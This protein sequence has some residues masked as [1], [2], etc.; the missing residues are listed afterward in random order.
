MSA[1]SDCPLTTLHPS[2]AMSQIPLRVGPVPLRVGPVP[3]RVGPVPLRVGPVPLR[4]GPV[5]LRVGPVP[6]H[7]RRPRIDTIIFSFLLV[8]TES[9]EHL[10][11]CTLDGK[12]PSAE[13]RRQLG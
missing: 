13:T 3:L 8:P 11:S 2:K 6:R 10:E 12:G 4:V 7:V 1:E 9:A 5:P